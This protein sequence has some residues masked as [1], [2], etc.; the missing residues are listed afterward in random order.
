M[1]YAIAYEFRGSSAILSEPEEETHD[2]I[3]REKRRINWTMF[4]VQLV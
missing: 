4:T 1:V 2:V 3:P